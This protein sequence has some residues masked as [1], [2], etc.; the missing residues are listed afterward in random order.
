MT[1]IEVLEVIKALGHKYVILT[2]GEPLI[3]SDL[4][5]LIDLLTINNFLVSIETSGAGV[6]IGEIPIQLVNW[7]VD[8]KPP[9]SGESKNMVFPYKYLAVTDFIKFPILDKADFTFAV[10]KIRELKS[11]AQIAFS[12]IHDKM[13]SYTLMSWVMAERLDAIINLQIHKFIGAK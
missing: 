3:Q 11:K 12:P 2:G 1:P 5:N 4:M 7:V 9:S 10:A 6:P 8:F 13:D